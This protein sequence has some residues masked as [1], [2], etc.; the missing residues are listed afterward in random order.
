MTL[1]LVSVKT[2][3][4]IRRM[5]AALFLLQSWLLVFKMLGRHVTSVFGN[6]RSDR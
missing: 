5:S 6:V 3:L 2:F 4:P 1:F